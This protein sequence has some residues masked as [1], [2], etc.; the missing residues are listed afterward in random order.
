ML[1][2]AIARKTSVS[3]NHEEGLCDVLAENNSLK[4]YKERRCPTKNF[5][6]QHK[7]LKNTWLYHLNLQTPNQTK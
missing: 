2:D 1:S 3:K 5:S 4:K 7:L 6:L